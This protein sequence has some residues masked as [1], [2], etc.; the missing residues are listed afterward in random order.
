MYKALLVDDEEIILRGLQVIVDWKKLGF[1]EVY[2]ASSG[3]QA[4]KFLQE[5]SVDFLMTDIC[6]VNMN[7]L[8]LIEQVNQK[9]R[10]MRIV[11][12]TGYDSFEYAQRCCKLEV[13]DF[14]L[15]PI[16]KES[17]QQVVRT[18][19]EI[20]Q[21]SREDEVKKKIQYR[22][23]GA[24][25]K[26]H[27]EKFC[28]ELADGKADREKIAHFC[29]EHH[30]EVHDTVQAI[31]VL[32]VLEQEKSWKSEYEYQ[33]LLVKNICISMYDMTGQG[34]TF[35]DAIGRI[36]VIVFCGKLLDEVEECVRDLK[37]I[38]Q[39][40]TGQSVK[41]LVGSRVEGLQYLQNSYL[42]AASMVSQLR[43]NRSGI[44]QVPKSELRLKI[45]RETVGELQK[46]MEENIHDLTM[47]LK[48]YDTY[49]K[50]TQ[51]YNLS[52]SMMRRTL[53]QMIS[54]LYYEYCCDQ[55][56]KENNYMNRVI[57]S[58]TGCDSRKMA[59][60]GRE[61]ILHL[62]NRNETKVHEVVRVA[63]EYIEDH[64]AEDL[65]LQILSEQFY[66]SP[67]YFSRLFKQ[68]TGIGCNEYIVGKRMGQAKSLLAATEIRS[69]EIANRVGYHDVNYFS[70]AFKKKV[71][72]SPREYREYVRKG[73]GI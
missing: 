71:G 61:F 51:S 54:M 47:L 56:E 50:S 23:E 29:M 43:E 25:D 11:V 22:A 65:S 19:L 13:H 26:L 62:F 1:E 27:Q 41:L 7:G 45:F 8:E 30:L 46:I 66:V 37:I 55:G 20:L 35:E 9:N 33:Y 39:E 32:P 69:G 60:I 72:M 2:T 21:K 53:Y 10:D 36:V 57:D 3:E 4:A 5:E 58:L 31:M 48:T 15:K 12:L 40:E 68:E 67:V 59:E 24:A 52:E 16:D 64:L 63:K 49:I 28:R 44:Y 73:K 34:V 14:L 38:L 18:Q 42:D 6:M 17:L 70:A